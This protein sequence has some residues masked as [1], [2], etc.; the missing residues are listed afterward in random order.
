M[1]M[2]PGVIDR[3]GGEREWKIYI[4]IDKD[5]ERE[6]EWERKTS[7]VGKYTG[8]NTAAFK[9]KTEQKTWN[10]NSSKD[11]VFRYIWWNK[12]KKYK[13]RAKETK[14]ACDKRRMYKTRIERVEKRK[15]GILAGV[16]TI[17][18]YTVRCMY[19]WF[20]LTR[21]PGSQVADAFYLFFENH[22]HYQLP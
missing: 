4:Y 2:P 21:E 10:S 17:Y 7:E 16:C 19:V 6:I 22:W 20:L 9:V 12:K 11:W 5:T 13:N 14:E 8:L 1:C 15:K 3:K 18:K